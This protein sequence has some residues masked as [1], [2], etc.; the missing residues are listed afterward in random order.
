VKSSFDACDRLATVAG[1]S[2]KVVGL[3]W[4]DVL[5]LACAMHLHDRAKDHRWTATRLDS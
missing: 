4:A 5:L 2:T 3:A 1:F